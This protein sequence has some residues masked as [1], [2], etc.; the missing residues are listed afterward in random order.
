MTD[1]PGASVEPDRD[2]SGGRFSARDRAERAFAEATDAGEGALTRLREE[3]FAV[4]A[5][6]RA[7]PRLR[8]TL[9]DIGVPPDAKRALLRDLLGRRLDPRTLSLVEDLAAE[10]SVSFRVRQALEDLGLEA[11]LAEADAAG[12]L[13]DVAAQ[14]FRFSRVVEGQAEL[15][16]ALIDPALPDDNKRVVVR[17]LLSG[18]APEEAAVLA[19][20]AVTRPGDPAERLR[21]LADR[22]AA[23]RRRVLV[24]A[25][26]A[27]P[28]DED[29]RRRL[30]VALARITGR[31]VDVEVIVDPS[32]VGGIV[33]RVGDEVIDG[34]VRRKLEL[35]REQ[36]TV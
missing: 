25:Y 7:Q 19:E 13:D 8:K 31:D 30:A 26:S 32:V 20:W 21:E 24:E 1:A 5:L 12:T 18:R 35:A 23:R 27:V 10:D 28:L 36:L 33:A 16:T 2:R 6:L 34:S 22:A 9:A 14:L 11:V 15:R 29:R 3:L 4:A 17:S